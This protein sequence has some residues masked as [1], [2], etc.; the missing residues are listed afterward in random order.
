[1][2]K[3][4]QKRG[5]TAR[6]FMLGIIA[7]A[8]VAWAT[9]LRDSVGDEAY[10]S[11]NLIPAF[12]YLILVA[13]GLLINPALRRLKWIRAFSKSELLLIFVMT[14]VSAGL[15]SWGLVGPMIPRIAA[16]SN[17]A[18]NTEQ[19]GWDAYVM[20]FVNENYF[21]SAK[22]SQAAARELYEAS[23]AYRR[24]QRRHRAAREIIVAR[25]QSVE[26]RDKLARIESI[27]DKREREARRKALAWPAT[28]TEQLLELAEATWKDIGEGDTP[29][30]VANEGEQR[31]EALEATR[32]ELRMALQA[33]NA[34][35]MA[36]AERVREG[37]P[38]GDRA[39]PGFVFLPGETRAGYLARLQRLRVGNDA[40]RMLR[41]AERSVAEAVRTGV[42]IPAHVPAEL[43]KVADRLAPITRSAPLQN[44]LDVLTGELETLEGELMAQR[45]EA[46]RIR[47]LRRHA[48][49]E[50]FSGY[51]KQIEGLDESI[52]KIEEQVE[53]LQ[54]R[55]EM[56]VEPELQMCDLVAETQTLLRNVASQLLAGA[57]DPSDAASTLQQARMNFRRFDGTRRRFWLGDIP[58]GFWI[59]PL[60]HWFALAAL[61]YMICMSFNTLIYRQWAHH[62]KLIYPVA[63]FTSL[64]AG[65]GTQN[66]S[67]SPSLFRNGLFWAGVALSAGILGWNHLVAQ[68][69][70]PNASSITLQSWM[71]SFVGYS[72]VLRGIS[73]QYFCV[74]F[75]VIG[76]SFLV[77]ANISFSLWF[78]QLLYMILLIL[79]TW[80]G[81]GENRQNMG[82]PAAGPLGHGAMLVFGLTVLWTCRH[83]LLCLVRPARLA[84]VPQDE[85]KEL[86]ASSGLFLG[87][88]AI[89]LVVLVGQFNANPIQAVVWFLLSL[90]VMITLMR[91]VTEGGILS[92]EGGSQMALVGLLFGTQFAWWDRHVGVAYVLVG[93]VMFS[94]IKAFLPAAMANAFKM[95]EDMQVRR[96]V[97]HAAIWTG[98]AVTV[99]VA[100]VTLIILCYDRGANSLDG[101]M[102]E[103]APK[104]AVAGTKTTMMA[105]PIGDGPKPVARN[106]YLVGAVMMIGLLIA[107]QR[108]FGLPHPLG[109]IMLMN[110]CMRGFWGSIL[111][112]W[113]AKS[114]VSRFCSKEQYGLIRGFFVGLIV[115]HLAAVLFGWAK[116][117]WH[118][119]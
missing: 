51:D 89:L 42:T 10:P 82:N 56:Y 35:H 3:N 108:V 98:I 33:L 2:E 113:I 119:G 16:L 65:S 107:R 11:G 71:G 67:G 112:G 72:G 19:S 116:L 29:Q 93:A 14:G 91:A 77:P 28:Q 64:L 115:G 101:W 104:A 15:A 94:S 111:L 44:R 74:I 88:S 52:D 20:P 54:T 87:A 9:V 81:Y 105:D 109:M 1:M 48:E 75:V 96:P 13:L 26:I 45:A 41:D 117:D 95:R 4:E 61:V 25:K 79:M 12:P 63:E 114:V 106:W 47:Q 5:V 102:T 40:L 68:A 55:I 85:R 24:A 39:V 66:G 8:V 69:I 57:A 118:W 18:W 84:N 32:D 46:R 73:A 53:T 58:W 60:I 7:A 36:E 17:P 21:I 90:I 86:R 103:H 83:Y 23:E 62:E 100:C 34:D 37:L 30:Q 49:Q 6:A 80:L 92:F 99:V 76:L 78:F 31:I 50:D 22:G 110:P 43:E 27:P 97:F 70:I 38:D 59:G